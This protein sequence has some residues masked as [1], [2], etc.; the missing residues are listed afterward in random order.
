MIMA[1]I[2]IIFRIFIQL[3]FRLNGKK[4][5]AEKRSQLLVFIS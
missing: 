1:K 5:A 2:A 4:Q 3:Y